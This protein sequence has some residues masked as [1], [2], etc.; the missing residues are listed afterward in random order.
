MWLLWY[1]PPHSGGQGQVCPEPSFI[2]FCQ[3]FSL[4]DLNP[5]MS[6]IAD[7]PATTFATVLPHLRFISTEVLMRQ[8]R[9]LLGVLF[10][11]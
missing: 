4:L 11:V 9:S 10:V 6:V 3:T 1:V 5:T 7:Y 2:C 8:M